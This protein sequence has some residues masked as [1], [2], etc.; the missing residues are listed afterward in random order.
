MASV[1]YV[2]FLRVDPIYEDGILYVGIFSTLDAAE[3]HVATLRP[4]EGFK[5]YPD[6]FIFENIELDVEYWNEGFASVTIEGADEDEDMN[7]PPWVVGETPQLDETPETYALRLCDR[8][9]GAGRYRIGV[10][11]EFREIIKYC[12]W[13]FRDQP[14]VENK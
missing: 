13:V 9:Y 11:S 5:D 4:L 10:N 1:I 8:Q 6:G 3:R 14:S 2:N 12:D 7:P